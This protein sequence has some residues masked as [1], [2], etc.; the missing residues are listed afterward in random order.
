M[1]K[2]A[3]LAVWVRKP[4]AWA[5]LLV[6]VRKV[7]AAA[8]E[9]ATSADTATHNAAIIETFRAGVAAGK[10]WLKQV[11][12]RPDRGA[13][14]LLLWLKLTWQTFTS[15][16]LLP[17][18][19]EMSDSY[20]ISGLEYL[21]PAG[22]FTL[23]A[24]HTTSRWLPRLLAAL[25]QATLLKRP[26]LAADWIV[27][28]GYRNPRLA[29]KGQLARFIVSQVRRITGWIFK[30]WEHNILRVPMASDRASIEALRD[31]KNRASR[32]PTIVFPEG[33]GT[34]T[35]EDVRPGSGRWL[36][37]LN[38]PVLPVSAWWEPAEKR[39]QIVIG[40][41]IEWSQQNRLHD[42]QIGL[43]I[44][45]GL[46][47]SEAPAWQEALHNWEAAYETVPGPEEPVT[48]QP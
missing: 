27:I 1:M 35:F 43:E 15:C 44:A 20:I 39:W 12:A 24:N 18:S 2:V 48:L 42:L 34:R 8:D 13:P 46:P 17:L 31:W 21:P 4:L 32:Q 47:A 37:N 10:K 28:V 7:Q 25:H 19:R 9:A 41:A 23:A 11:E 38:V 40:P 3:K 45:A 5:R 26:E 14:R 36:A 30:R 6:P 16:D 33:R 29:R 22:V